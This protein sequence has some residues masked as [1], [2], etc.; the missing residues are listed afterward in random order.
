MTSTGWYE[1]AEGYM[2]HV[3]YDGMGYQEQ[4]YYDCID[5]QWQSANPC[6]KSW[7]LIAQSRWF[8]VC[9]LYGHPKIMHS[10]EYF[11]NVDCHIVYGPPYPKRSGNANVGCDNGQLY[12]RNAK[13]G[14]SSTR[15]S[16]TCPQ[17]FACTTSSAIWCTEWHYT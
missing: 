14:W 11:V 17:K 16:T 13:C 5:G 4:S 1:C 7:P 3:D 6:E 12:T 10:G 15:S 9:K 8:A 2:P